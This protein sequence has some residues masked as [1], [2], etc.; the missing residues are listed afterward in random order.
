LRKLLID[1][2]HLFESIK[3]R[4]LNR[5]FLRNSSLLVLANLLAIGLSLIRTPLMA[6]LM[7]KDQFGML[8]VVT[9]WVPF[10]QLLSIPGMDTASYH[11]ISKG[12]LWAFALNLKY[13]LRWSLL[14]TLGFAVG[15]IYWYR[16]GES[17]LVWLFVV[18]AITYPLTNG[19]ISA[20]GTLA[21]RENFVALFWYRICDSITDFAGFLPLLFSV[22]WISQVVTF[23]TTNQL[24][25]VVVLVSISWWLLR[26]LRSQTQ[27]DPTAQEISAMSRYGYHQTALTS[28]SVVQGRADA[29]L[30]STI[31]A[32]S[33]MADYSIGIFATNQL[34]QLWSIYSSIRYPPLARMPVVQRRRRFILEGTVVFLALSAVGFVLIL[35]SYWLIPLLFPPSYAS[36]IRFITWL[37]AITLAGTPG[38]IAESYFRT[39]QDER[40]Q[41]WMRIAGAIS[42]IAF[43]LLLLTRWGVDGIMLGRL[44]SNL[45]F[46]LL[47]I[48][49]F[50]IDKPVI[51]QPLVERP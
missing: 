28:I 26:Q 33:T 12:N 11:Y 5:R 10:L 38:G 4:L 43:P 46:S 50:S 42:S 31:S 45:L 17:S 19:L 8:A 15:A 16:Q 39:Q 7:P 51:A 47:G 48:W 32:L 21:A 44:A 24:V 2:A 49:F 40:H 34:R 25:M 14:S 20:S 27:Q 41:Y 13:R 18:T 3:R 37:T 29:L 22:V 1:R 35:L 30:I 23:Y 6:W 36:S 9:A